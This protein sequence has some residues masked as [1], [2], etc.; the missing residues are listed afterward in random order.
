[1][2]QQKEISN[3]DLFKIIRKL[4]RKGITLSSAQSEILAREYGIEIKQHVLS[5]FRYN[6]MKKRFNS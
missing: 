3:D 5:E 1:L 6:E 4:E 2:S